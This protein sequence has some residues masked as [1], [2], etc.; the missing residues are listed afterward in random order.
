M[1]YEQS[2]ISDAAMTILLK[3]LRDEKFQKDEVP[4]TLYQFKVL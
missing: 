1:F 2:G 4:A 3:I